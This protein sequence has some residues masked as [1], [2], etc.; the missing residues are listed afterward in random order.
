MHAVTLTHATPTYRRSS[1]VWLCATV[2]T[3]TGI[4]RRW[5]GARVTL[6]TSASAMMRRDAFMPADMRG[7]DGSAQHHTHDAQQ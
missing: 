1:T 7:P 3:C 6:A 5:I 4:M 2:D